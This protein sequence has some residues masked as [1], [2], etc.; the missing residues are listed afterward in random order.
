MLAFGAVSLQAAPLISRLD[1]A[2]QPGGSDLPAGLGPALASFPGQQATDETLHA[3]AEAVTRHYAQHDRPV[4]IVS[5]PEGVTDEGVVK[6]QIDEARV[7]AVGLA[8]GKHW[9]RERWETGLRKLTGRP[10]RGAEL[11]SELDW[12]NRHPLASASLVPVPD[13]PGG[14]LAPALLFRISDDWPLRATLGYDNDGTPLTGEDRWRAGG[15]W[16]NAFGSGTS[17]AAEAAMGKT[18]DT[19]SSGS[20]TWRAPLPWRH[21]L[22]FSAAAAQ[23][24]AQVPHEGATIDVSGETFLASA[25]YIV[26]WRWSTSGHADISAGFDYKRFDTGLTF[27]SELAFDQALEV[28]AF[29]LSIAPEWQRKNG[30]HGATLEME[31]SPGGL[32]AHDEDAAY[33]AAVGGSSASFFLT[34]GTLWSEWGSGDG[35]TLGVKLGGQWADGPLLPSEELAVAGTGLVRGYDERSILGRHAVW[36]S[37]E[38]RSPQCDFRSRWFSGAG[39]LVAF[40]EGG[41]AWLSSPEGGERS[42]LSCGVGL[43]LR[44]T[45]KFALR[46]DSA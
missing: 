41:Q 16:G 7:G 36:G 44:V 10:V 3:L 29:T 32:L 22:V 6:I 28:G 27:G 4:V 14:V 1:F 19:F 17:L 18:A 20:L 33:A 39:R 11:Q 46:C 9:P 12:L 40:A 23:T 31:W 35:P 37:L 26:P 21:E 2:T 25:R 13:G 5:L 30:S 43:R 45:E 38:A 8:G 34:R 24:Q 42:L 15:L